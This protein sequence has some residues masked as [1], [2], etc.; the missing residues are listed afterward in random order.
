MDAGIVTICR[1][2]NTAEDGNM[3]V[4]KLSKVT[5][6]YY[7]NRTVSYRRFY[8]AKGA[9][10]EIDLLIRIWRDPSVQRGQYAVVSESLD[11]GQYEIEQ[12]QHTVDADNLQVT[13]LTLKRVDK[14]YEVIAGKAENCSGCASYDGD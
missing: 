2:I 4:Y 5:A 14:L 12:V 13:D 9:N 1:L 7:A 6:A 8:A 3:P 10:E 11:N